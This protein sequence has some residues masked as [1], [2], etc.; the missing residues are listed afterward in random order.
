VG[1]AG[2]SRGVVS[3]GTAAFRSTTGNVSALR[4]EGAGRGVTSATGVDTAR[5]AEIAGL[6]RAETEDKDS[7]KARP[8][9][10]AAR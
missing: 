4:G 7:S 10:A 5:S 9:T 8:A 3:D 1:M 2:C 6:P